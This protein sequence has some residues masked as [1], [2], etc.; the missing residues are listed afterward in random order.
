[1]GSSADLVIVSLLLATLLAAGI[2][3]FGEVKGAKLPFAIVCAAGAALVFGLWLETNYRAHAFLGAKINMTAAILL[4]IFGSLSVRRLLGMKSTGWFAAISLGIVAAHLAI[5]IFTDSY[6]SGG[7]ID[8]PWGYYAD[9]D[10]SFLWNPL[11]VFGMASYHIVLLLRRL[12]AVDIL[13]RNKLYFILLAYCAL[14]PTALDYLPHFNVPVF[15]GVVSAYSVPLFLAIFGYASLRYRLLSFREVAGRALGWAVLAVVVIGASALAS[16]FAARYLDAAPLPATIGAVVAVLAYAGLSP[17]VFEWVGGVLGG[18]APDYAAAQNRLE[19]VMADARGEGAVAAARRF[20][21]AVFDA[22]DVALAPAG[23]L[24]TFAERSDL[25]ALRAA[26]E[27]PAE[28]SRFEFA[29][30]LTPRE[31]SLLLVGGRSDGR[32]YT[33][34]AE[35]A[36]RNAAAFVVAHITSAEKSQEIG[37]RRQLDRFISPQVVAEALSGEAGTLSGY[38]R[39]FVTIL[40][41]DLQGFTD[42]SDRIEGRA[43]AAVLNDYW[44][45]MTAAADAHGGA[46]DKFIGDSVMIVFGAPRPI[47]PA[48]GATACAAM[49]IEMQRRLAAL[50]GDWVARRLIASPLLARVGI[51]SG[52]AMVGS[53]GD[54]ARADYTCIGRAVNL[55]SRIE[56]ACRPGFVAVSEATFALIGAPVAISREDEVAAKGL[57]DRVRIYELDPLR[58]ALAE[59]EP[60]AAA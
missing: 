27:A 3:R 19:A 50:N 40:F 37:R 51:H 36:I 55:A 8:Y 43:L 38:D 52:E 18:A 39:R 15:D 20:F 47:E 23:R 25:A 56:K 29:F 22:C 11:I 16:G 5:V 54:E 10:F 59:A 2:L 9:A 28:L 42:L 58:V 21:S 24:S 60:V 48:A 57:R 34:A 7:V 1:M 31:P 6:F 46:V 30:P 14:A 41:M 26:G 4:A 33:R 12:G 45:E 44:R 17:V 35:K 13:T 53:F 49:A 32:M